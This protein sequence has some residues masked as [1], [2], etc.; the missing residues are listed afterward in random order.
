MMN[1]YVFHSILIM[2]ALSTFLHRVNLSGF[3]QQFVSFWSDNR[4]VIHRF[5]HYIDTY[6]HTRS[7]HQN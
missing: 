5:T 2:Q 3:Q 7:K 4:H 6:L 1:W